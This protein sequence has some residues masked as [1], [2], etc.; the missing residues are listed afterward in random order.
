MFSVPTESRSGPVARAAARPWPHLLY[1]VTSG[2]PRLPGAEAR[3]LPVI[4]PA[5]CDDCRFARR[6]GVEQ[7]ACE[8]FSMYAAGL[9]AKRWREAP[10]AP[11]RARFEAV[12]G[13][14]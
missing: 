10:R 4:E 6:C 2:I 14:H 9:A 12:I 1:L 5:P 7:L 11:T 3:A 8:A 13:N